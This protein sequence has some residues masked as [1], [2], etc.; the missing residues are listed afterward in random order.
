MLWSR[1]PVTN[2]SLTCPKRPPIQNLQNATTTAPGDI[3]KI[4]PAQAD[5]FLSQIAAANSIATRNRTL[6]ICSRFFN[7]A[8]KTLRT[9]VNPFTGIK[10]IRE[11][12]RADI[13]YCTPTEREEYI[14]AAKK[15]EWSEWLAI[16][17]AFYA[18]LRREEISR[19][20]W[21]DIRFKEGIIVVQETKTG[22]P[23]EVPLAAVLEKILTE[24]PVHERRGY[25]VKCPD[26]L[27]RLWRMD[28]PTTLLL[29]E[30][31]P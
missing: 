15:S 5:K 24:V 22:K 1:I 13:V 31:L 20:E 17:I 4:T 23:R 12:R 25:V 11:E 10:S 2:R 29:R 7:W 21:P 16:P 19:L 18:G 26:D 3:K 6:A 14:A 27:D 8:V 28:N 9:R 30:P